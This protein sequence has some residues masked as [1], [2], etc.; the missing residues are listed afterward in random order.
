MTT[1][2]TATRL[3]F[4]TAFVDAPADERGWTCAIS[5]VGDGS[6]LRPLKTVRGFDCA[7]SAMHAAAQYVADFYLATYA[8]HLGFET[9]DSATVEAIAAEVV[10]RSNLDVPEVVNSAP[11]D[12]VKAFGAAKPYLRSVIRAHGYRIRSACGRHD[13]AAAAREVLDMIDHETVRLHLTRAECAALDKL[14]L[15]LANK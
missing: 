10:R 9:T 5:L 4:Q 13:L 8:V 14:R 1:S 3:D 12:D 6:E 2:I 11:E 7:A 15:A